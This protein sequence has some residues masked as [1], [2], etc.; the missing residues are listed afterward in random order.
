MNT[1]RVMHD[2]NPLSRRF[3]LRYCG[4]GMGMVGLNSLLS[5]GASGAGPDPLRQNRSHFP[6]KA[7]RVIHFFL[8][9]GPSHVDTFDPK[10]ALQKYAGQPLPSGNLRT[11]R[12]T[13]AAFP[14]PFAFKRYGQSGIPVS[15]LFPK[16][17]ACV[18]DIAVIRSMQADLPNHE[19]SLMLMNCGDSVLS[20]PSVGSW[21]TY[22]L[23]ADNQNLPAF[24]TM[25]PGG[26][27]IKDAQ[28]WQAGF[29][30]GIYQGTFIDSSHTQI[31]KLIENIRNDVV[32]PSAQRAQLDFVSRL[33]REHSRARDLDPALESRIQTFEL[34]YR[35]QM[36]ATDAFDISREPQQMR[37]AYG[38]GVHGRQTLIARRLL[39]R[40]VRYVQLWH[41][42]GQPWDNHNNI[43]AAH[44]KLA[45][46]ID[47]PVAAL[48]TDLKQRGMLDDTLVIFGGEFG[49][50][51]TV[52][53]NPSGKSQLGRDHN[54]YG[55]SMWMAGGGIKGGTVFGD[56]D[57]FGFRAEQNIVHVH[58]LH[59]TILHLLGFDHE[60]FTY[61]YASRDFRLTD[62]SGNV[63]RDIL[64]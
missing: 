54:P 36:E 50:T 52:E 44:L 62:V 18:D 33:N 31:D 45:G 1:N 38:D 43:E 25:C 49:R 41:G 8:N 13:G 21:A 24:I 10:P 58:D 9:G 27:P 11:E 2:Q 20:R 53:L 34:A 35:M 32:S 60:E 42:A 28:N 6:G 14:S 23:G 30:P 48:L 17:G 16:I 55:F 26:Y 63:V 22:G 19:P 3:F 40:G 4:M 12:K 61:R 51:P 39:E 47:Q 15:S 37:D 57:E 46:E 5:G 29:L 59:A 7:K 64:V 56:T